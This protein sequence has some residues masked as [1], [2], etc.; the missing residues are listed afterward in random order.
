LPYQKPDQPVKVL[1]GPIH[2]GGKALPAEKISANRAIFRELVQLAQ[3]G[4]YEVTIRFIHKMSD[5]GLRP[6]DAVKWVRGRP[7]GSTA[8]IDAADVVIG[9]GMFMY[10]AVARGKPTIGIN[11]HLRMQTYANKGNN[12]PR[13]WD[14]YGDDLAYPINYQQGKLDEL[15]QLAASGEQTAWRER[16]IGESMDPK[17]FVEIVDQ[18]WKESKG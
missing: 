12:F 15:I 17:R 10:L 11:Q 8:E 16:F 4:K 18:L 5:Q 1:F 6:S 3:D 2:P 13:H 7:D 9:E 14:Q